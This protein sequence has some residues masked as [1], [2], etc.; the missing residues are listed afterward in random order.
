MSTTLSITE[1][2]FAMGFMFIMGGI[3][4]FTWSFLSGIPTKF[5][6]AEHESAN[7]QNRFPTSK[8]N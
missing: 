4:V 5:E 2:I 8:E 6:E 7:E 1:F 3:T